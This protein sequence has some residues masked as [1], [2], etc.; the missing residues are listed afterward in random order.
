MQKISATLD[1][2][3]MAQFVAVGPLRTAQEIADFLDAE[4]DER[5]LIIQNAQLTGMANTVSAWDGFLTVANA[6]LGVAGVVSA[7]SGAISGVYAVA[8]L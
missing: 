3:A 6:V 7:I 4:P 1:E 5:I 2:Q 8:Q